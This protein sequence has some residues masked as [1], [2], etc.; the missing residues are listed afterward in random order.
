MKVYSIALNTFK[1]VIRD[2]IFYSLVFFALL[3]LGTSVLLSTLTLG[4]R[5]KII[6]DISLAGVSFFGVVISIFV[7]I[8]L[9]Y[10]ELEKKTIYTI[11]SKPIKRYQFLLGKYLGLALTLLVYVSVMSACI[12]LVLYLSNGI[13]AGSLMPAV[14]MTYFEF[15]II[16]AAA[17]LFSTFSTPTLSATYTLAIYIIGHLTG[18]LKGL[19]AKIGQPVIKKVIEILYYGLPNLENFNIKGQVVHGVS[20]PPGYYVMAVS[21]GL[22][23]AAGILAVAVMVFQRRNFK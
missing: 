15:L 17:L 5:T 1:E 14:L 3:M 12:L 21:Y 9:V 10:K 2:K 20:L 16:T 18:D 23:Y 19:A 22:L 13:W 11:I 6:E 7:G 8:G 4:E